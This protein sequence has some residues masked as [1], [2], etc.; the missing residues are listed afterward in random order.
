MKIK[1]DDEGVLVLMRVKAYL[2][3]KFDLA[4]G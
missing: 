2:F 4:S 3:G 1:A